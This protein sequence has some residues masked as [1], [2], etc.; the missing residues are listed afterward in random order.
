M[1]VPSLVAR[2][3]PNCNPPKTEGLL[4]YLLLA[5]LQVSL[6]AGLLRLGASKVAINIINQQYALL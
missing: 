6:L 3:G 2:P 1:V 4:A 5:G